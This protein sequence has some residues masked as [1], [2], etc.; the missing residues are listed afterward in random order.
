MKSYEHCEKKHEK[1]CEHN[2]KNKKL[3]LL[4][5]TLLASES[6][7][8]RA[9]CFSQRRFVRGDNNRRSS[10]KKKRTTAKKAIIAT[11]RNQATATRTSATATTTTEMTTNYTP[12]ILSATTNIC[13]DSSNNFG[14]IPHSFCVQLVENQAK[15][16]SFLESFF[17]HCF[18]LSDF[19]GLIKTEIFLK[20]YK[21]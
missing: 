7:I 12:T 18:G 3:L 16:S 21:N 10:N 11:I 6:E 5:V 17:L 15:S 2:G 19:K 4:L 8:G 9:T 20:N 14:S 1:H 13:A